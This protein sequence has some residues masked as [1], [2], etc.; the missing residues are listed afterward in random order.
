[1]ADLEEHAIQRDRRF[2]YRLVLSLVIAAAAGLWIASHLTST[3]TGTCA[4]G[5]FGESAPATTTAP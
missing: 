3:S 4:A 1:M 2:V 5:F